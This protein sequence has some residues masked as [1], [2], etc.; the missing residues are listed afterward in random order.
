[1]QTLKGRT[2]ETTLLPQIG[3]PSLAGSI[4]NLKSSLYLS[5]NSHSMQS[6]K[7]KKGVKSSTGKIEFTGEI[8]DSKIDSMH[9]FLL[10]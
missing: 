2:S 8:I 6:T 10:D 5:P 3:N 9:T 7:F 1:M 4:K